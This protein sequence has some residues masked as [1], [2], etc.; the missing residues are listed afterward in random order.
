MVFYILSP[1]VCQYSAQYWC[2]GFPSLSGNHSGCSARRC[3]SHAS[4]SFGPYSD[5]KY[6]LVVRWAFLK[7]FSVIIPAC[8]YSCV[9]SESVL[10]FIDPSRQWCASGMPT[11][12]RLNPHI[13]SKS[14]LSIYP[15]F[16]SRLLSAIPNWRPPFIYDM[17]ID[18]GKINPE[19]FLLFL[20]HCTLLR[21]GQHLVAS[22]NTLWH[23]WLVRPRNLPFPFQR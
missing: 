12:V 22:S 19:R 11:T 18:M 3:L 4:F 7:S 9:S 21:M 16:I 20:V 13:N 1:L 10:N 15:S 6:C 8:G 23:R 5:S 17:A 14:V 2:H